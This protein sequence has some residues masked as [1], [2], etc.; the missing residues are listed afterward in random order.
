MSSLRY[1]FKAKKMYQELNNPSAFRESNNESLPII[2]DKDMA[3]LEKAAV[4][5]RK[6]NEFAAM[7]A[8]LADDSQKAGKKSVR[9]YTQ[10]FDRINKPNLT[11]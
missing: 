8:K 2:T 1:F 6:G 11:R 5:S 9:Q 7:K 3:A 10:E 4:A